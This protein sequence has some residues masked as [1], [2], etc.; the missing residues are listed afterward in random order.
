[1]IDNEHL[2]TIDVFYRE[3]KLGENWKSEIEVEPIRLDN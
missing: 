1:V 2:A 3:T